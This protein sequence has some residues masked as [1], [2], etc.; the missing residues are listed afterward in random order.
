MLVSSESIEDGVSVNVPVFRALV[1]DPPLRES[2]G[3]AECA[4]TERR[5]DGRH[6]I[7]SRLVSVVRYSRVELLFW[8]QT[9]G[10]VARIID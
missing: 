3:Q 7:D 6:E 4:V 1:Y 9:S 10:M 8:D 5:L 2:D